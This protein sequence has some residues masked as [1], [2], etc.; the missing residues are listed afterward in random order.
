M[1]SAI[2]ITF[3]APRKRVP[4]RLKIVVTRKNMLSANLK[5]VQVGRR[6][7]SATLVML[8]AGFSTVAVGVKKVPI[9]LRKSGNKVP[10]ESVGGLI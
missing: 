9:G 4:A 10:R 8:A 5:T 1:V 7:V 6:M 3:L 2:K